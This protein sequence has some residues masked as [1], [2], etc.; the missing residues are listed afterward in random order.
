MN[1]DGRAKLKREPPRRHDRGKGTSL[2][3]AQEAATVM[4]E[5][6]ILSQSSGGVDLAIAVEIR[7]RGT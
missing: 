7:D 4:K 1:L 5:L 6:P 2:D 3:M